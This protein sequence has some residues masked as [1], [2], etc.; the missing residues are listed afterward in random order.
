LKEEFR[1][2]DSEAAEQL[3]QRLKQALEEIKPNDIGVAFS[4]GVDSSLLAKLCKD[5]GKNATLLTVGFTSR[6]DIEVSIE[7]AAMLDLSLR[8]DLVPLEELEKGLKT[9]L[10]K[11]EFDRIV[12]FENCVC[13]YYVFR[14]ASREE[15]GTVVSANGIDELFCGYTAY[16]TCY[17]D[18]TT[19][20][21]LMKNLVNTANE[22]KAEMDKLASLFGID[23]ACPFLFG[24]FVNF[25]EQ[26]PL[27]LKIRGSDDNVRKHILREV[28]LDIGVPSQAALRSKK[29]FQYS[30]GVHK[31][32][33]EL[34]KTSGFTKSKAKAA[35]FKTEMDNYIDNL[36]SSI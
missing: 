1:V 23:Y 20:K 30:S 11:I 18:E 22:D 26:I 25:A 28:A 9:V 12:R 15:L 21:E 29:A 7:V 16:K 35:G 34:A 14:L 31:A 10:A 33:I 5:A 2:T 24:D 3:K 36:R 4:G 19:T 6:T 27:N 13:F 17:G 32:I 8:Y